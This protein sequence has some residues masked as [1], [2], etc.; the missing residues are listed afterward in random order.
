MSST[1]STV[2]GQIAQ[3]AGWL[4]KREGAR[5]DVLRMLPDIEQRV[6]AGRLSRGD[7]LTFHAHV[8]R[9]KGSPLRTLLYRRIA[10]LGELH[11]LGRDLRS[12]QRSAATPGYLPVTNE[13]KTAW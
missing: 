7:L 10:Q 8:G 1:T 11:G 2:L 9:L 5:A 4:P 6:A 13:R 3:L 12:T